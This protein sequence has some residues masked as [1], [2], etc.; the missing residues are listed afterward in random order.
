MVPDSYLVVARNAAR[1]RTN[2]PN[3]N[4]A[5]C[6]GDYA[7]K[8]SHNGEY[9]ALTMPDWTA[10]TNGQ[11]VVTTNLMHIVVNDVTYGTGGRWGQW[12]G[13][14]WQQPRADR[15]Q[16]QPR[17]WPPTG[18]TATK[19][20]NPPGPTSNGPG[21]WTTGRIMIRGLI[22][23]R[24]GCWMWASAWWITSRCMPGPGTNLVVNPDFECG[25]ANWRFKGDH[26]RS[27]LENSGYASSHSLHLRCSDRMWT[28]DNSCQVAL[29]ANA[30]GSGQTAT[31]RFKA[32][33]LRG[34]PEVVAAV[35]RQ[36][37][38]SHRPH[39]RAG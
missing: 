14:R 23:R 36:L 35:E 1:L 4:P 16:R 5:N 21:C 25:L 32:R 39:A 33:W 37:A 17:T 26:A 7:G 20:R 27:S 31:L 3:L 38:G 2:Y 12:A 29:N 28:G 6:L 10:Q 30:L 11:G 22:T 24:L 15:S 8:L 18:A 19:R 34:W 13:R 9:L